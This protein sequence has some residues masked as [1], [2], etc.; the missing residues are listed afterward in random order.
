MMMEKPE[1]IIYDNQEEIHKDIVE[2]LKS[3]LGSG[4]KEAYLVGSATTG[5]F[6]EYPKKSEGRKE[7]DVDVVAFV[8][9]I[10]KDWT[11]LG[12]DKS[13]WRGYSAGKFY[14]KGIPHKVEIMVVKSGKEDFARDR[15]EE[16][17]WKPEKL[18]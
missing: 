13:W 16:L 14:R 4:V 15:M 5:E 12:I 3:Q 7:S 9:K 11:E 18:K 6:G 17:G 2:F 10:P 8:D 1:K